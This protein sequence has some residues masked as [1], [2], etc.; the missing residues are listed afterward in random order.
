LPV[1]SGP[2]KKCRP[3]RGKEKGGP[4]AG[5]KTRGRPAQKRT[6]NGILVP[7]A[8]RKEGGLGGR[9]GVKKCPNTRTF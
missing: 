7:H 5:K 9:A 4:S 1:R 2:F 6:I 3:K 8:N